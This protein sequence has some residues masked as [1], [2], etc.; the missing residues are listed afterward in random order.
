[1]HWGSTTQK[2]YNSLI[3]NSQAK[4]EEHFLKV[5]KQVKEKWYDKHSSK[6]SYHFHPDLFNV[7]ASIHL[8]GNNGRIFGYSDDDMN[9][10]DHL[11][12]EVEKMDPKAVILG[13]TSYTDMEYFRKGDYKFLGNP[14]LELVKAE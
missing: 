4:S 5:T 10:N 8:A 3:N 2:P 12:N 1:L 11:L 13:N 9:S 7:K 14:R 6:F